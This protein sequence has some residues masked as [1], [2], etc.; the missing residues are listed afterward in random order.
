MMCELVPVLAAAVVLGA[1][2]LEHPIVAGRG[3]SR[4]SGLH[5]PLAFGAPV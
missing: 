3:L 2:A 5:F 1:A 4:L